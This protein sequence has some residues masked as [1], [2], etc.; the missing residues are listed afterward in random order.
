[1]AVQA[2]A[3]AS[4][5]G[6]DLVKE[7]L[8]AFSGRKIDIII[9]NATVGY[10]HGD[11][12]SSPVSEFDSHFHANVRAPHSLV[13]AALPH[14]PSG[15]RIINIGS[16]AGHIGTKFAVFYAA[17]KAALSNLTVSWAEELGAKGI[18]VNVVCPGPIQTDNAPP[19]EFPLTQKFRMNQAFKRNGTAEE[20]AKTI[21]FVAGPGASFISGQVINV[22][23]GFSYI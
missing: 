15:G 16:L 12:E 23:G 21:L 2:D 20:C 13:L 14:I 6:D 10:F 19:E 9:N 7:T 4:T 3:T 8:K 17:S 11:I 18:T 1:M 5:F 22:D